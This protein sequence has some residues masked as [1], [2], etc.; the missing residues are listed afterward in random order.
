MTSHLYEVELIG[1]PKD[2]VEMTLSFIE[3]ELRF[4]ARLSPSSL[5]PIDMESK[6]Q[7]KMAYLVYKYVGNYKY[8]FKE[9][10]NV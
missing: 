7:L 2:G 3:E 5:K 4:P 10:V 1:G 9:Y 6:F 8:Q